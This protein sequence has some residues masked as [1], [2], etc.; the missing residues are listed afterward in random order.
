MIADVTTVRNHVMQC[1]REDAKHRERSETGVDMFEKGKEST[2]EGEKMVARSERRKEK[3]KE[4]NVSS[5]KS[6][7]KGGGKRNR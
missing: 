7:E 3:R 1:S 4:R 5:V 2:K 6:I